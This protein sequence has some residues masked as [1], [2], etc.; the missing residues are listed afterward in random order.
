MF[1]Q[2]FRHFVHFRN[3]IVTEFLELMLVNKIMLV[4]G[5]PFYN[6]SP[7]CLFFSNGFKGFIFLLQV[8]NLT[9]VTGTAVGG[10]LPAQTNWPGTT[11]NTPG[12]APS[13]ARS[14]TGH[15]PGRTTSPYT[16]KGTFKSGDSGYDPHCQKRI[17]YFFPMREGAQLESTTIMVKFP[18]SLVDGWQETGG[19][20]K[21]QIKDQRGSVTGSSNIPILSPTWIFLDLQNAKGVTGSCGCQGIN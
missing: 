10:S 1:L 16:W 9:T 8:R 19:N 15:S 21:T 17:Q 7:V 6:T 18:A 4:S 12:T 14:A 13:S 2:P 5:V 3:L 11:E 20:P